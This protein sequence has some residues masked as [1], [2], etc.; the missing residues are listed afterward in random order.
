LKDFIL[1]SHGLFEQCQLVPHVSD[2]RLQSSN[3]L[4]ACVDIQV[5]FVFALLAVL[6]E[7]LKLKIA[8][9]NSGKVTFVMDIVHGPKS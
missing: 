5:H 7:I 4:E 1:A 8:G 2:I 9:F 6:Q 3:V